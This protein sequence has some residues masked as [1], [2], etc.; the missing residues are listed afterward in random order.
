M[1][2]IPDGIGG[3]ARTRRG[4]LIR[5]ELLAEGISDE[6]LAAIVDRGLAQRVHRG[7]A[8]VGATVLSWEDRLYAATLAAGDGALE[9][10]TSA[11]RMYAL[12][13]VRTSAIEITI[14]Y[15]SG[16]EP[17]GVIVHRTRRPREVA[18]VRGIPIT[19]I[20]QTLLDLAPRLA[21]VDLLKAVACALRRRM[22]TV[23]ALEVF[24]ATHGGRGVPGVKKLRA[25]IAK[26]QDGSPP[27]GSDGEVAFFEYLE[28]HGIELPKRQL[29][30]IVDDGRR[31]FLDFAWDERT[32]AIEFDGLESRAD[33]RS[34]DAELERQNAIWDLGWGLR[35][36][37]PLAL[38]DR[39]RATYRQIIRFLD[40]PAPRRLL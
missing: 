15:L 33:P 37:S 35:R 30:V 34:H 14:D 25:A 10:H 9:S 16:A 27:P 32:K 28:R 39:P 18:V 40:D 24:L 17:Q 26:Y 6:H 4:F 11:G 12:D 22:T 23:V 5:P 36:F 8:F 29:E 7:V 2:S 20:E 31:Y 38:R 19:T 3:L 13:G 21:T 1:P